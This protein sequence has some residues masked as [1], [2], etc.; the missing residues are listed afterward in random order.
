MI[1]HSVNSSFIRS[2]DYDPATK[3]AVVHLANDSYHFSNV[4]EDHVK[5]LVGASSVG[6]HF[7][8]VFKVRHKG[9]R[10]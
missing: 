2:V 7:N 6:T 8:Q 5:A 4:P 1:S 10:T 9:N 3:R